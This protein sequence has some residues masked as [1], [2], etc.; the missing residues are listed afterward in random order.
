[1]AWVG[2]QTVFIVTLLLSIA[3]FLGVDYTLAWSFFP[4]VLAMVLTM[5]SMT[6]F[7]ASYAPS[8]EVGNIMTHL[9]GILLVMISPVFFT[10]ERAPLLLRLLG[11]VSLPVRGRRHHGLLLRQRRRLV[12]AGHPHRLRRRHPL[13]RPMEAPLARG[14][15][16]RPVDLGGIGPFSGLIAY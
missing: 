4:L 5:A 7:I 3:R 6:L 12:R 16:G 2:L 1:M 11:H 15:T 13:L 14:V 10:I 9:A 8:M